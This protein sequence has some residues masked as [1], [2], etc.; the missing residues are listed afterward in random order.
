VYGM[1]NKAIE[2][3]VRSRFGG[4]VWERT[5]QRAGVD[6]DA[7]ISNDAYPDDV[8]YRLVAAASEVTGIPARDILL[9]FGEHWVLKIA[10][11]EYAGMLVAG[12]RTL[13]E[14]L[15]NLPN[16]HAR[17]ALIFPK[18]QP[19]RFHVTEVAEDSLHLHYLTHRDGLAAFVIGIIR[20]LGQMF[21]NPVEITQLAERQH[22]AD[23]DVF[24]LQWTS[25]E[26]GTTS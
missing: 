22:G 9:A 20:G 3:L 8:T 6:V 2:D 23:H 19:P 14:F 15:L 24:L 21:G 13:P 1:V 5:K 18:L 10:R 26:T 11:E 4:E 7:F 17:V 12:G 25:G 16:F